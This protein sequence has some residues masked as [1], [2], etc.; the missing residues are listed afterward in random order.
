M[1]TMK[2]SGS[3]GVRF[4][5]WGLALAV[6]GI[7]VLSPAHARAAEVTTQ[8]LQLLPPGSQTC[9]QPTLSGFTAYV[10]DNALHSFEFEVSDP[11][12]VAIL[13]TAGGTPIHFKYMS[14]LT[15]PGGA[16]RVHVDIPSTTIPGSLSVAVTMISAGGKGVPVCALTVGASIPGEMPPAPVGAAASSSGASAAATTL[17]PGG[18][19]T[20]PSTQAGAT[21]TLAGSGAG[22][23]DA[24][25]S[26]Q[27]VS[28]LWVILLAL[29]AILT[30][31][32]VLGDIRPYLDVGARMT[33]ALLAIPLLLALSAW[34]AYPACRVDWVPFVAFA[35]GFIGLATAYKNDPNLFKS[36]A[37]SA[38]P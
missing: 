22:G 19:P 31:S 17:K 1:R 26:V 36:L 16:L 33:L 37:N 27:N 10:Y 3:V 5:L 35:I 32:L 2:K 30:A 38:N 7:A 6:A 13:G 14:R 20:S 29:Y 21:G 9:A 18:A 8:T 25:C 28:A 11:S 4:M 24:E 23:A 12:Y 34:Y 15:A